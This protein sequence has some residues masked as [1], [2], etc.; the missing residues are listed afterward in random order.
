MGIRDGLLGETLMRS[1]ALQSSIVQSMLTGYWEGRT[2][3]CRRRGG[4]VTAVDDE[5]RI[6]L[7]CLLSVPRVKDGF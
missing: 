6:P 2:A 4:S 1:S 3:G 5:G 7:F